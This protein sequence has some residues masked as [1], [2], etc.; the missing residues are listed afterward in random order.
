MC[1]CANTDKHH[2]SHHETDHTDDQ[3]LHGKMGQGPAAHATLEAM[4]AAEVAAGTTRRSG[5]ATDALMW[6]KRCVV[7]THTQTH[8]L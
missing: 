3:K 5:S 2:M 6:L 4:I 8:T 7:H 1:A